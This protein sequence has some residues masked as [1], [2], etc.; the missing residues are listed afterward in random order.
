M[1]AIALAVRVYME[2][3][4]VQMEEACGRGGRRRLSLW[5]QISGEV[6]R[7]GQRYESA[8]SDIIRL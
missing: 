8:L 5:Q 2:S 7:T 4:S 3:V 1:L 6:T